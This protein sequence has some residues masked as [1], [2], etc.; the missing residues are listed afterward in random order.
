MSASISVDGY[1]LHLPRR[2]SPT[3]SIAN[4]LT[5]LDALLHGADRMHGWGQTP[6]GD[7]RLLFVRGFDA[8]TRAF[9]YDVNPRFGETRHALTGMTSPMSVTLSFSMDVGPEPERQNF[10]ELLGRGRD[11]EGARSTE[12]SL[13]ANL[14]SEGIGNPLRSVLLRARTLELT[15]TAADSVATLNHAFELASDSIWTPVVKYLAALPEK[16]DTEETWSRYKEARLR[17][18]DI[19][20]RLA[21]LVTAQ[22][23]PRQMRTLPPYVAAYLDVSS[24]RRMRASGLLYGYSGGNFNY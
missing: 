1:R 16:F 21:P 14:L 10:R 12:S 5:G 15:Q 11:R 19:L 20:I 13:R 4:P 6:V 22:L 3:L 24:L 17:Q 8:T 23:T 2:L 7:S 9:R 18:L